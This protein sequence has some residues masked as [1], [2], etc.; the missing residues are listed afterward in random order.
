M[1][2]YWRL[3]SSVVDILQIRAC[4]LQPKV[5]VV[6]FAIEEVFQENL[7]KLAIYC[8]I[9]PADFCWLFQHSCIARAS[10]VYLFAVPF[11]RGEDFVFELRE[12]ALSH[13]I[14][15]YSINY[16]LGSMMI[17]EKMFFGWVIVWCWVVWCL[18]CLNLEASN[19]KPAVNWW[20]EW[21]SSPNR[22]TKPTK[23]LFFW[24]EIAIESLIVGQ[25]IQFKV[26]FFEK[27]LNF[28]EI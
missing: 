11:E 8:F 20:R 7:N 21:I 14:K 22:K 26:F 3:M 27:Y 28:Y 24:W 16:L 19:V 1:Q 13:Q 12:W 25:I 18:S 6:S 5:D 4:N 2:I 10:V 23:L 17:L 15:D 9:I